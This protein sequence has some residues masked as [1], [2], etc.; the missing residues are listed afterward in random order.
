MPVQLQSEIEEEVRQLA[1]SMPP[2]DFGSHRAI[3]AIAKYVSDK[4]IEQDLARSDAEVAEILA[5][6]PGSRIEGGI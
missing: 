5:E 1:M 2:S 4:L 6:R 3:K